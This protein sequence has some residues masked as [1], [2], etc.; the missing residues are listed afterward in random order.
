MSSYWFYWMVFFLYLCDQIFFPFILLS[1]HLILLFLRLS[2]ILLH[3]C[4]F[5]ALEIS[6][7]IYKWNW[8]T[9]FYSYT[10]LVWFK[11]NGY[12]RHI[13]I[14]G[15]F[16]PLFL[17]LSF[18]KIVIICILNVWEHTSKSGILLSSNLYKI[19]YVV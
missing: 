10:V 3:H 14:L 1:S 17:S 16:L 12:S 13:K 19:H 15:I 18:C 11:L 4:S 9:V 8:S 6:N 7:Y 5:S 2:S